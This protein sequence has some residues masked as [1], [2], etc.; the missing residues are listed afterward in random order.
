MPSPIVLN[1][2]AVVLVADDM[3]VVEC[4][5]SQFAGSRMPWMTTTISAP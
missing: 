5:S 4:Y 3:T 2:N 1:D